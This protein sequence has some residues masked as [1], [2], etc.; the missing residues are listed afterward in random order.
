[1]ITYYAKPLAKLVNKLE[2]FPGIGAKSAQ[3]IAFYILSLSEA[4]AQSLAESIISVKEKIKECSVC[5]NFSEDDICEVCASPGRDNEILCVV[6]DAKDLITMEKTHEYNG[7][8]HVLGGV[9]S[10]LDNV[11]PDD[12]KIRELVSRVVNGTFK[13]I[14][15]ALNPTVEGDTTAMYIS[16]LVKNFD[17]K[18]TRIGYGMPVGG[19]IDYADQATM[20]KALEWR[21]EI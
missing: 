16:K 10:P 5:F 14:I 11:G 7:F 2:S 17:V 8:Y 15:V 19:E 18:V 1:M 13:E 6:S 3:R 4:E 12:I 9:I 20:I 21:R